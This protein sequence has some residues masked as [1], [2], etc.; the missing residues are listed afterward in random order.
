MAATLEPRLIPKPRHEVA[1]AT[2]ISDR[3]RW[4][5]LLRL[6]RLRFLLYNLLPVGLAVAVSV[7]QGHPLDLTWYAV[8]QLFAWTV[9]VMTHFCNEYFDLEADRANV[10]FTP[11]T[12]GSRALV[13]GMV[14][15]MVSLGAGFVL[16]GLSTLMVA[17]MPSW[18]A[19]V[20]ATAAVVLAWFYTAPPVRLNYR[21][22]GELTVAAILNGLWPAV[23]VVLQAGTVPMLLLAVLAPTAVLQVARMMVMNLGDRRS[24]A[25]VGKRTLPVIVG[26]RT[27]V[28][29]IVGAQPVAYAM[30]TAFAL[31]GWVP[32]LV[33]AA[34]A[35][36]APLSVWLVIQLRAGAMRDLDPRRMTP[37]VFWASNHVSLIVAAAMLGVI[38]DAAR[39]S[40]STGALAVLGAVFAG[41]GLLF[42]YR[43]W[44]ARRPRA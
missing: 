28:R 42:A 17:I 21:G 26:Y 24:D 37:V 36:T 9:H 3:A 27:A 4:K 41:Y 43:L 19:R 44:L 2:S 22:A 34:M 38:L 31:L 23:A 15:P 7:H 6:A 16:F 11:W 1:E 10:Y 14:A 5:G 33:W 32:W 20:L 25:T 8:A 18:Q 29:L 30:L 13:D 39:G 40:A 12:G 35:A